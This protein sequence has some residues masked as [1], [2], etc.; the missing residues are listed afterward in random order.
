ML[1]TVVA[2]LAPTFNC[3]QLVPQIY[4]TYTTKKVTDLSFYSIFL[5]VISSFSWLLHGFFIKDYSVMISASFGIIVNTVLLFLYITYRR[6]GNTVD[7]F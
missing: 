7:Q 5:F 4:K 6:D 2:I 3:I 1:S